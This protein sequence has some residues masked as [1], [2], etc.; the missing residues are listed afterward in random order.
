MC[1]SFLHPLMNC[2]LWI[3]S[4]RNM[5]IAYEVLFCL[6]PLFISVTDRPFKPV[7]DSI[8]SLMRLY[9]LS[10]CTCA[11]GWCLSAGF[12]AVLHV[13]SILYFQFITQN[14]QHMVQI[15][16]LVSLCYNYVTENKHSLEVFPTFNTGC[17]K[18]DI[19][20]E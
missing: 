3:W 10:L 4:V 19:L 1:V 6:C 12:H 9:L 7:L 5:N 16:C 14:Y 13:D 17:R 20:V 15:T 18:L 2:H 11:I 8:Y